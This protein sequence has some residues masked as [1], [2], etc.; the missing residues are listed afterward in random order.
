MTSSTK[1][2]DVALHLRNFFTLLAAVIL[3]T[4]C[5]GTPAA[6]ATRTTGAGQSDNHGDD[7]SSAANA[8]SFSGKKI[9]W[10]G[11]DRY[12]FLMDEQ[13]LAITP[14]EAPAGEGAGAREPAT[15]QRRCIV[16]VPKKS[17]P[18]NPWSWRGCYWD[19]QPQA[20]IELLKRGFHVAYIS[21]N[22]TLKPGKEWD[23][24]Y[25]FLTGTHG[26][27][28]KPAFIGMSLGGYYSYMWATTH[29]GSVSCIYADNPGIRTE[30]L[31]KLGELAIKDVPLLHVCGSIDP[32]LG[33]NS[34]P[35][36]NIY[37]QFGGRISVMIKEGF[38]HHPHSLRDPKPIADFIENSFNETGSTPPDF[39]TQKFTS[40]NFYGDESTYLKY[41]SEGTYV[42]CRGPLF[43]ECYKRYE[44]TIP[45]IQG[46]ISVIAPTRTAPGRPWVYRSSFVDRH[47]KVDLALLASGFHIVKGPVPTGMDGPVVKDWNTVY[48]YLTTHGFSP[49]P[50]L[51]G[52]G[53]A[54]GEAYAWAIENPNEV[55]C[56][57]AENPIMHSNLAKIQPLEHLN[58]LITAG[59]PILHVCGRL[60]P[61]LQ[62]NTL[63]AEHR[64]VA[65]GGHMTVIINDG[66]GHYLIGSTHKK[67][68]IDFIT[69]IAK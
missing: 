17:A 33:G 54:A 63:E 43:S 50:V 7:T 30:T 68:A 60:D 10:H 51:E 57:Y 44:F 52:S 42:T 15:G 9:D 4:S 59:V 31:M 46:G 67:A 35:I 47:E 29:P 66:E 13:T 65:L 6:D 24:W 55:S 56:I 11:F 21:A 5:S 16:V 18:E 48:T 3:L 26:L 53:Q 1:G 22:A 14:F 69:Q 34:T 64:Y 25:A 39:L 8:H 61:G 19:H 37:Q 20:E 40:Y 38:A 23:A 2:Y 45:G 32:L 27:S 36:E 62:D 28:P 58:P 12:D 41:P 49:K